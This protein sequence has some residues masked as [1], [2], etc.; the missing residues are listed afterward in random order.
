MIGTVQNISQASGRVAPGVEAGCS[1]LVA[2][3]ALV[4]GV[5]AEDTGGALERGTVISA[6]VERG[7]VGVT[8][9]SSVEERYRSVMLE[10]SCLFVQQELQTNQILNPSGCCLHTPP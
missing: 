7:S 2:G 1:V 4:C 3:A 8:E 10:A 6:S 9:V 5:T